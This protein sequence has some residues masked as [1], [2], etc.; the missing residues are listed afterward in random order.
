MC[1]IN[2]EGDCKNLYCSC[3]YMLLGAGKSKKWAEYGVKERPIWNRIIG[4][5]I[6]IFRKRTEYPFPIS[7][8]KQ[9]INKARVD[10][11]RRA[12]GLMDDDD[13]NDDNNDDNDADNLS[14]KGIMP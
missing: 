4:L 8:A 12:Y 3:K 6:N 7:S 13:N 1:S 10:A 2:R 9:R 5:F 14:K 11:L